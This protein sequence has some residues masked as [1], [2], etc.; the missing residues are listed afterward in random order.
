MTIPEP[1]AE[2]AERVEDIFRRHHVR[3]T[4]GGEPTYVPENPEGAE[5]SITALGP[6]KLRYGYALAEA[7]IEQ[8]LP[9]AIPI[10]SPGKW[11]PGEVNPR[12]AIYLLW[13]RDKSPIVPALEPDNLS[14]G[15]ID[16][17]SFREIQ[18]DFVKRLDLDNGWL[19]GIDPH[20]DTRHV[21]V[22]PLDFED[23]FINVDWQ[24]GSSIELLQAD[25]PAG[26]RL[27]L[28][29]LPPEVCRRALVLEIK[30]G[31]L[32]VFLP[33]FLQA[34]LLELM[35]QLCSAIHEA[36]AG[37]PLF[38]GY[39]PSD[40]GEI[41][42]K[43]AI[44]SD[45]GVLE[46][47]LPP[48]ERWA[49]YAW[50]L[51][52]L[53]RACA[54]AGLRS[55]KRFSEEEEAGTGGGNHLLFG[56]PTLDENPLFTHPRWVTSMLRYWQHHP[57][58]GYLF[59]G[60]YVGSS[61]QAP[62]PDECTTSLYDLEMAYRF[63]EELPEGDHRFLISET[64]RHLHTD[65]SGNSHRSETSFDKFWNVNFDGG[66]RG[67][68]EFRAVES[69]PK[70]E[71]MSAVALLW[72]TLAAYLLEHPFSE[73]LL[74][75]GDQLHDTYFLPTELWRDFESVLHDL[76][77]A[78]FELPA[79]TYR[80]IAD[81]R[82]PVM[83][84]YEA[85]GATLKVRK[86]HEGWPL[87]CEQPLEGGNTSRFVD[88][89]IERLEFVANAEFAEHCQIRIQGRLLP[90]ER[91]PDGQFGVGLRYRRTALYPSLH[92]GIPPHM[93]L[94]LEVTHE[95]KPGLFKLEQHRRRFEPTEDDA[96][97]PAENP[98]RKLNAALRT[99]DLR[100]P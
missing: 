68:I 52:A 93:P 8:S 5:W 10:Y 36:N 90:L 30:D 15:Q 27:P 3:L 76:S 75:F 99:C 67:L 56:G 40:E 18:R 7:L 51:D 13:N 48:C 98:C 82:F 83:L 22:L 43:M 6:T 9:N 26:L 34:P 35:E 96:P 81:W 19:R 66:C 86:A 47:N 41:W 70:A 95:E 71:W 14:S 55:F 37:I 31:R 60:I 23:K 46:I 79:E 42:H 16:F 78:G 2:V 61:S 91:L 28:S 69:L 12:W 62:R 57:S 84:D 54:P 25:G 87:L 100:L 58:L 1:L 88:T 38:G 72:H 89:S 97:E 50:W 59:T 77:R 92:P 80:A 74:D 85:E 20:D 11:Y 63:L 73:P 53:E 21:A 29:Q 44:A 24:L 39:I 33:P 94:Y 64:L 49:D 17:V 32:H 4:M 45:P 65:N